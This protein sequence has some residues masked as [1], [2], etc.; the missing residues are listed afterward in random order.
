[1]FSFP[2]HSE[3][4]NSS[5]LWTPP[6]P[7]RAGMMLAA[8][9]AQCCCCVDKNWLPIAD[10]ATTLFEDTTGG[11]SDG[12]LWDECDENQLAHD[13]ATTFIRATGPGTAG[14]CFTLTADAVSN[15][16][17]VLKNVIHLRR[18][19]SDELILGVLSLYQGSDCTVGTL[20][21]SKT[22]NF[23]AANVWTIEGPELTEAQYNTITDFSN[24][25]LKFSVVLGASDTFDVTNCGYV[26][27]CP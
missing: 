26:E 9:A 19:T 17:T 23:A 18:R 11:D 13:D 8:G 5:P 16:W 22:L 20:I 7:F 25:K 6:Q 21:V 14:F 4:P 1:V 10:G 3:S 2:N 24:L 27:N 12:A 15:G